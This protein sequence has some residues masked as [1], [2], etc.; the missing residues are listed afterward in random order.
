MNYSVPHEY[1]G[2]YVDVK[3]TK[4]T[5]TVYYKTNQICSHQRLYGRVNQYSTNTY[6]FILTFALFATDIMKIWYNETY[7]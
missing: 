3:L 6:I 2:N 5:V 7:N 1:V 4:S